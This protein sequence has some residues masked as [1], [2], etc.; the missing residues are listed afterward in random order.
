MTYAHPILLTA[1][2]ARLNPY[3]V[4]ER[5]AL[6]LIQRRPPLTKT[7]NIALYAL[8]KQFP[9]PRLLSPQTTLV[10]SQTPFCISVTL[11]HSK[12]NVR[13]DFYAHID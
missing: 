9:R 6:R 3:R 11:L 5:R 8:N 13:I 12:H 10:I 4:K 1:D 7:S 2:P